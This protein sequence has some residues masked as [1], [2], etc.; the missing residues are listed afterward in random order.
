MSAPN[1]RSIVRWLGCLTLSLVG[2]PVEGETV[3]ADSS[4]PRG[5]ATCTKDGGASLVSELRSQRLGARS[6]ADAATTF[7]DHR[8]RLLD[9][10]DDGCGLACLELARTSA[11]PVELDRYNE[12]ACKLSQADGCTLAEPPTPEL[13]SSLCDSGDVL[14]CATVLALAFEAQP[15]QP[16]VWDRVA[17]ASSEGCAANDGRSC[18]VEA[19][20]RCTSEPGCDATAITSASKAARLVPTPE[21]QEMLALVQCQ[22]G[23]REDANAT[24]TAAC[25]AG[26]TDSCARRCELLRDDHPVL[27]R[28]A[29]R[30]THDRILIAMALQTDVAPHWYVALSTMD[31]EQ[32]V[33]FELMLARFTPPLSEAGAKATVPADLREQFP[34]LV[35]AILRSPQVDA[36]KIKYW[37]GRL[38]DMT[39]E[40]RVNLLGSLRN[41]W[42]VIPGEP[43]KSPHAFVE[44]VRLQ[45]GGLSPAWVG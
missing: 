7:T 20:L 42:W 17:R 43:G 12:S 1:R 38:P 30:A 29:D 10:C 27:V 33:A 5:D 39:Q 11:D 44:R 40:Q 14:A 4:T 28:E 6:L 18:S 22:A 3:A 36:K 21:V 8:A 15:D 32:L 13:A 19:W 23:A 16:L 45:S 41:Q 35:E 31:S 24:L 37:F 2:C 9:A 26:N 34:V 25:E